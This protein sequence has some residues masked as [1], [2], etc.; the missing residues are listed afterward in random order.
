MQFSL[1]YWVIMCDSL[2][3]RERIRPLVV[4]VEITPWGSNEFPGCLL[5]TSRHKNGFIL[6]SGREKIYCIFKFTLFFF[7][8]KDNVWIF[9]S[10]LLSLDL[11]TRLSMSLNNKFRAIR[12][13]HELN[14]LLLQHKIHMTMFTGA[15]HANIPV[16]TTVFVNVDST[17]VIC[18]IWQF[19]C[20]WQTSEKMIPNYAENVCRI[21]S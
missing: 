14:I 15:Y 5:S 17:R 3:S 12:W 9:L 2:P 18:L 8:L 11:G 13:Q 4:D 20:T 21:K 10:L 19:S 1:H 7:N 16:K 6:Y